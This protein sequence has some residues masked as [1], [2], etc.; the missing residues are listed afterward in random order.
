MLA[1]LA[2]GLFAHCRRAA[3]YLCWRRPL[4]L[5]HQL[6]ARGHSVNNDP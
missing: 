4:Q 3:C 6:G 5:A 1:N 2:E